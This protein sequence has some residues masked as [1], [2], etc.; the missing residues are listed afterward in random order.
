LFLPKSF[1]GPV[2]PIPPL[3]DLPRLRE[4][5]ANSDLG[6]L[7]DCFENSEMNGAAWEIGCAALVQ[8]R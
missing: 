3:A 2:I 6:D 5:L 7:P 4:D 8:R 1:L